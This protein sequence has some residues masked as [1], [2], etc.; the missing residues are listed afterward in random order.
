MEPRFPYMEMADCLALLGLLG[1]SY[2]LWVS[3]QP[4]PSCGGF[5]VSAPSRQDPVLPGQPVCNQDG[6]L[7]SHSL[8]TA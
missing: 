7:P 6:D 5:S 8:V 4:E 2:T 1:E 3:C